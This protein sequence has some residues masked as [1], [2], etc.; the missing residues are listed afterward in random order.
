MDN[1]TQELI[2]ELTNSFN[3]EVENS[4]KALLGIAKCS[5]QQD[6]DKIHIKLI[7]N[8]YDIV[9]CKFQNQQ[10]K[11]FIYLTDLR[12][13]FVTGFLIKLNENYEVKRQRV[14]S[15]K[16]YEKIIKGEL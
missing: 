3:L 15:Q 11:R 5:Y 7:E 6:F 2:N 8:G 9:D 4:F 13:K 10:F 14:R 16:V 12:N 1:E